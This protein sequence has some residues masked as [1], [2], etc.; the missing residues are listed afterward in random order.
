[1]LVT[2]TTNRA[3]AGYEAAV[4]RAIMLGGCNS[5][6]SILVGGVIAAWKASQGAAA[7]PSTWVSRNLRGDSIVSLADAITGGS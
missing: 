5:S 1:M 6:R 4:I 7:V 3:E 2:S